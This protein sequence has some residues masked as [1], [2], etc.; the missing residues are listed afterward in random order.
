MDSDTEL[1]ERARTGDRAAFRELVTRHSKNVY[2]LAFDLT[3]NREDAEDVSQEVF[4]RAFKS[5]K[6][7]RLEAKFSSW[8]YRITVNTCLTM[9]GKKSYSAMKTHESIEKVIDSSHEPGMADH[10]NPEQHTDSGFLQKH[11][12][13]ALNVLSHRERTVFIMRNFS[14]MAFEEITEILKIR[15]GTARNLNFKALQKLRKEL[16]FLR[17]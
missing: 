6:S 5:L 8:L 15:P 14:E 9:K 1:V 10:A 4:I 2:Y 16:K 12:D 3:R 17:E 7:F 11:L 13:E